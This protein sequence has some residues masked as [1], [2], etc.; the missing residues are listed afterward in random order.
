M[1]VSSRHYMTLHISHGIEPRPLCMLDKGSTIELHA[2]PFYDFWIWITGN[3]V[4]FLISN[5]ALD[6][7]TKIVILCHI[8]QCCDSVW[9]SLQFQQALGISQCP[10]EWRG[11]SRA[12]SDR[13][14]LKSRKHLSYRE[15]EGGWLGSAWRT[16]PDPFSKQKWK[17]NQIRKQ[18][19]IWKE[20]RQWD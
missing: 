11:I 13:H 15:P 17:Q 2:Q 20:A 3:R 8:F 16:Q 7:T 6:L 4:L 5:R 10:D 19:K 1:F 14:F 12:Y 9:K 18:Q